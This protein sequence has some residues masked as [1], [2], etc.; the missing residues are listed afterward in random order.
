MDIQ[1]LI[2]RHKSYQPR[3]T[4]HKTLISETFCFYALHSTAGNVR[5]QW[6]KGLSSDHVYNTTGPQDC[7]YHGL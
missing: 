5:W 7:K 1:I 3:M 4:F 2:S 6:D